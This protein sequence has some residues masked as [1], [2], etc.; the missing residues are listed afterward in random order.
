MFRMVCVRYVMGVAS[1]FQICIYH[2]F[3]LLTKLV[4]LIKFIK[5]VTPLHPVTC[6]DDSK[7][8]LPAYVAML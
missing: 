2:I 5:L 8:R 6:R 3:V 4:K 1:T 7:Q